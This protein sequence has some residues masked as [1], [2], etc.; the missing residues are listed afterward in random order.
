MIFGFLFT[1][2]SQNNRLSDLTI[3][4]SSIMARLSKW[5]ERKWIGVVCE[6]ILMDIDNR[7]IKTSRYL[8]Y[9]TT[10]SMPIMIQRQ[11]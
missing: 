10:V 2:N 4:L 5:K 3:P 7:E 6:N 9:L 8:D 11:T 1:C